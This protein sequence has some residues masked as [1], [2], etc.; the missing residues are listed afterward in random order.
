MS[1]SLYNNWLETG[2]M[3][4]I[5]WSMIAMVYKYDEV[6]STKEVTIQVTIQQN[7]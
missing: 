4:T 7:N 5:L 3:T 6:L 2:R 1:I